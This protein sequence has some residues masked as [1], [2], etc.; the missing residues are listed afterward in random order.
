LPSSAIAGLDYSGSALDLTFKPGT[1]VD[2]DGL[3]RRLAA[4][5]LSA[6]EDNGKWTIKSGQAGP[7]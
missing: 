4:Q 5:S 7:H 2:G 3:T 6:Q 1:T